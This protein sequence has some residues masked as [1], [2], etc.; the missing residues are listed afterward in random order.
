MT[1][2]NPSS[3]PSQSR[4]PASRRD[5][6]G[7][8]LLVALVML[9]L[10]TLIGLAAARTQT[11]ESRLNA[12]Q[13]NREIALQQAEAALRYAESI[14]G[15]YATPTAFMSNTGGLFYV[16]QPFTAPPEYECINTW[17]NYAGDTA[18]GSRA[19]TAVAYTNDLLPFG[20]A[21]Y[22]IELLPQ[23]PCYGCPVVMGQVAQVW[24]YRIT[25]NGV[26]GDGTSTVRVQS[27]YH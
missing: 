22:I 6:S 25:A 12:N 21:S 15:T 8:A 7:V 10:I 13:A 18:C 2:L 19:A 24:P 1:V 5:Q 20:S 9:L 23:T 4:L 16:T 27:I 11:L 17:S 26:G 14:A 3:I